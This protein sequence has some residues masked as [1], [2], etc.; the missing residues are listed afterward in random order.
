[1]NQTLARR[2]FGSTDPIGQR[3]ANC[4]GGD[5]TPAWHE[6]VGITGDMHA[7]GLANDAPAEL[8]YPATQFVNGTTSFIV[9]GSE[10]VTSLLPS[11]RRA[12]GS[13]D[14]LVA[15]SAVSTMDDAIGRTLAVPRFTMW[16]L[17]LLGATGLILALVGVYGVISYVVTQRT[18]EM[19]IRIALG[20]EAGGIQWM[21]VR[22]GLM[23]GIIGTGIGSLASLAATR[24]V[25]RLI[26]GVTTHDPLTFGI[27]AVLLVLVSVCA[28]WLPARRA[29]RI[30][31]LIALRGG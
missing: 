23:L 28:S 24:Y 19:G 30:D 15:L 25:G 22:Q 8:Y 16:L 18:R 20:A 12:V 26:F 21:L 11:I 17:S 13:V 5:K 1:V 29:T 27:V 9:R 6:I 4:I 2:L 31:P 10:R 14:P 3:V 7:N